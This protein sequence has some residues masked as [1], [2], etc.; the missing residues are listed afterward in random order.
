MEGVPF[1]VGRLS[2]ITAWITTPFMARLFTSIG[3]IKVARDLELN[4]TPAERVKSKRKEALIMLLIALSLAGLAIMEIGTYIKSIERVGTIGQMNVNSI[5]VARLLH[6]IF[7]RDG[8][9]YAV[10]CDELVY[11]AGISLVGVGNRLEYY[12]RGFYVQALSDFSLKPVCDVAL[13]NYSRV[14]LVISKWSVLRYLPK[15]ITYEEIVKAYTSMPV[16]KPLATIGKGI[17]EVTVLS[18]SV[19]PREGL[20]P[21]LTVIADSAIML[22]R[23]RYSMEVPSEVTYTISV[24]GYENY[25]ITGWPIHWSFESI[26]P[27]PSNIS[28]DANLWINFT[29]SPDITYTITWIAN[30]LYACLLYTSPSPRDRG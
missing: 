30:D 3:E 14:Y 2:M 13:G 20:G 19:K 9:P 29:G 7:L 21:E 15:Y 6:D 26:S 4:I 12:T 11:E 17:E 5:T 27:E 25:S 1:G 10:I 24:R 16:V 8:V 22:I 18:I 28:L 23:S